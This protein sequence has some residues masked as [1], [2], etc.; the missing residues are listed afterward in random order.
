M[1]TALAEIGDVEGAGALVE[2]MLEENLD[3]VLTAA[4]FEFTLGVGGLRLFEVVRV[5]VCIG[6]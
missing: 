5:W 2:L 6:W 4:P 3:G 1:L